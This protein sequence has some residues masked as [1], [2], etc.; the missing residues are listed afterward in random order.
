[1]INEYDSAKDI[2]AG[3]VSW[4]RMGSAVIAWQNVLKHPLIGNGFMM[5]AL[6]GNLAEYMT[7]MGNG[8]FGVMNQLGIPFVLFYLYLLFKNS[9][10]DE[11]RNKLG[12]VLLVILMTNGEFFLNY[13]MFWAL[14]FIIYPKSNSDEKNSYSPHRA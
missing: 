4:T 8:F 3:D 12:L 5:T 10:S 1:M 6:Y 11:R 7:G 14:M 13:P 2:G 9:P